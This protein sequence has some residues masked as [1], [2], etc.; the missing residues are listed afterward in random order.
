MVFKVIGKS[1]GKALKDVVI[2]V[3]SVGALAGLTALADPAVLAPIIAAAP[4][5]VGVLVLL[6]VP[7][8]VKAAKD[9]IK[10]R[11]KA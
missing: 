3:A 11:D 8:V 7:V 6:V 2:T 10:H 1:V 5:P 4:G 9:A